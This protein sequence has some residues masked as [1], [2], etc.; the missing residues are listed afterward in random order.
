MASTG[1]L[2]DDLQLRVVNNKSG[3]LRYTIVMS[4]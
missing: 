2:V 4:V 3:D 1:R